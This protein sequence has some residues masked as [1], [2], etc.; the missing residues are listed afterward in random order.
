MES[1]LSRLDDVINCIKESHEYKKC[2]ELQD[3]MSKNTEIIDLIN[4]IKILQKKYIN[5]NYS[6]D[7]K[8]ELD[9]VNNQLNSIP[10][11]VSYLE[12]LEKV[13]YKIEYVKDYLN[14]YFVNLLNS[15]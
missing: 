7:I 4:K 10:I 9:T 5:S 2:L 14:N 3:K 6:D 12:Y 8:S 13:N 15:K 11:Y 1:L